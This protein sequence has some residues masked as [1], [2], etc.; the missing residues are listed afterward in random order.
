MDID[1]DE[2]R[3]L[4]IRGKQYNH[5][6]R[7]MEELKHATPD[8]FAPYFRKNNKRR[9]QRNND[10]DT[11]PPPTKVRHIIP[12]IPF[13]S[14]TPPPPTKPPQLST[15]PRLF[16]QPPQPTPSISSQI[17]S[18]NIQPLLQPTSTAQSHPTQ[19]IPSLMSITFTPHTIR[20]LKSR[21]QQLHT[22][23][24]HH[25]PTPPFMP[26]II[27]LIQTIN[28]LL[29]ILQHT[30]NTLSFLNIQQTLCNNNLAGIWTTKTP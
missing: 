5:F 7:C 30:T 24:H 15:P 1:D 11:K 13:P 2:I 25:L 3:G 22:P 4:L 8:G 26:P 12:F 18:Q 17:L 29:N 9:K 10:T 21:L 14:W 23:K 19:P 16:S 27:P 6:S 28:Y 20:Q